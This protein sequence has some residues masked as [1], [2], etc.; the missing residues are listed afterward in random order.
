MTIVV[1]TASIGERPRAAFYTPLI[2]RRPAGVRYL[3]FSARGIT[4]KFWETFKAERLLADP[5]RDAKRYKIRGVEKIREIVPDVSR[6]IWIDRHCRL[7][8]DPL[9]LFERMA[10]AG[11]DLGVVRHDRGCIYREGKT[12]IA[13]KKDDPRV[14]RAMMERLRLEKYPARAGL[15]FGGF[16]AMTVS[17]ASDRF[18]RLWWNY[19][20]NGS[21]RDQLSMPV[22]MRR[23]GIRFHQW[24]RHR[25]AFSIQGK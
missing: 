16:F 11:A 15:F 20:E 21:R 7:A 23:T 6:I 5:V 1:I 10:I 9:K 19:V 4:S 17:D 8:A 24:N 25:E 2:D 13:K 12:C 14:I 3:A 22:A 18:T